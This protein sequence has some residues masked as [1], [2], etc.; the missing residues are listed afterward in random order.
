MTIS[1]IL[2]AD[3][4]GGI[5]YKNDLPWPR[6]KIDMQ[7]FVDHTKDNVVVMGSKTWFSLGKHAPLKDRINYIISSQDLKL[8]EGAYDSYDPTKYSTDSILFAIKSRH[9][10]REIFVIGGKTVYDEAY[11]HCNKI[12]LTRI[13]GMHTVDTTVDIEEYLKDF[14]C[15]ER[16][17]YVN[18]YPE[19]H[20]TMEIWER[21]A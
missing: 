16:A 1:M 11:K 8:F 3:E 13:E 15:T 5:G 4:Y 9:A 12:Y 10:K 14:T 7:W 18:P 2:A 6:I 21:N 19:P 20:C 17:K